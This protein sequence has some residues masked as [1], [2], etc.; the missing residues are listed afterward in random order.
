VDK[1]SGEPRRHEEDVDC[2]GDVDLVFRFRLGHSSLTCDLTEGTLIGETFD[3][4]GIEG[5]DAVR[6]INRSRR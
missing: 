4:R 5:S 1:N 6:M 3:G 2:D